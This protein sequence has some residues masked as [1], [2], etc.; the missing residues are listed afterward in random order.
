MITLWL[1]TTDNS[2]K[3]NARIEDHHGSDYNMS[4]FTLIVMHYNGRPFRIIQGTNMFYHLGN[5][6]TKIINPITRLIQPDKEI[7]ITTSNKGTFQGTGENITLSGN[8]IITQKNNNK[9]R[10]TTEKLN[11]NTMNEIIHTDLPITI[12]FPHGEIKSIGLHT[13]IREKKINLTSQVKGKYYA[14]KIN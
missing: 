2:D 8:V 9:I 14:P 12:K 3:Y 5:N 4:D 10:L 7:W 6:S 1:I 11:I 13:V